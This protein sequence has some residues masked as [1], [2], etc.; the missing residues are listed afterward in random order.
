MAHP[1]SLAAAADSTRDRRAA[2]KRRAARGLFRVSVTIATLTRNKS[3]IRRGGRGVM[4]RYGAEWGRQWHARDGQ[5]GSRW[6]HNAA[7]H[8]EP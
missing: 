3:G 6:G 5:P 4:S 8:S 1:A 7:N 2:N